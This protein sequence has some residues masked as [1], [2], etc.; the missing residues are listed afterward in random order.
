[1]N[2]FG[3]FWRRVAAYLIDVIVLAVAMS[4]IGSIFGIGT[5]VSQLS[6][7]TASYSYNVDDV[8]SGLV[9]LVLGIA[10]FAG[11]ESSAMQATLGKKAL[12]M[13][14]TDLNGNRISFLRATGRYLAKIVSAVIL[15]IGFI[16]VAFTDRKQGLHDMMAGTLVWR[17]QPG[18]TDPAVFA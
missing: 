14:V 11:L 10:Y 4:I 7:M 2:E 8:A 13:V 12:G 5:T 16:M 3:G 15:L 6:D 1:M 9:S 17:G 18:R